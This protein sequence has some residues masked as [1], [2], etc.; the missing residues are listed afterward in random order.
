MDAEDIAQLR[1]TRFDPKERMKRKKE[2]ERREKQMEREAKRDEK[3]RVRCT[4]E[5]E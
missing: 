4:E 2:R 5:R 3:R 1:I